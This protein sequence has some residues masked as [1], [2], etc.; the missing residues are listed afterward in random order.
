MVG[1][2]KEGLPGVV[3]SGPGLMKL[4]RALPWFGS[5]RSGT[6]GR[7]ILELRSDGRMVLAPR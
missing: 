3:T 6:A 1:A 5:K 4:E 7:S 2:G